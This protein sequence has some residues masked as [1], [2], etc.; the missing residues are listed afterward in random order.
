MS[1]H[2]VIGAVGGTGGGNFDDFPVD[3][4]KHNIATVQVFS[5]DTMNHMVIEYMVG[6]VL[7]PPV[8]HGAAPG[9]LPS[10]FF[11]IDVVNGERLI[12]VNGFV[13]VFN[14]TTQISG[15]EL[16]TNHKSSG[17]L[18]VRG[19]VNFTLPAVPGGSIVALFG[20]KGAFVDALGVHAFFP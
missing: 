6:T 7:Q 18:G 8:Q 13:H 9:G 11:V 10:P 19:Q 3:D 1:G 2:M 16:I 17:L 4:G 5:G 14:S 12:A 15:L 20:R